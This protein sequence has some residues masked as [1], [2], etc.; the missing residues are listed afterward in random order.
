VQQVPTLLLV[1]CYTL[2]F[3]ASCTY[4]LVTGICFSFICVSFETAEK[5]ALINMAGCSSCQSKLMVEYQP[6]YRLT[7][8]PKLVQFKSR[9]FFMAILLFMA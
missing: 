3:I 6:L 4:P 1:Y 2:I 9:T 8:A 5:V 7:V